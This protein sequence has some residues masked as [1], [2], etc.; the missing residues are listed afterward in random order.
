MSGCVEFDKCDFCHIEKPVERTYLRP[1]KYIKS[2][3]PEDY[4]KLYNEGAYFIIIKTC[5]DCGIPKM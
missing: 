1:S 4:L 3:T 5:N 2:E